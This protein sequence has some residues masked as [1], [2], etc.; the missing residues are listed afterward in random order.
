M[1]PNAKRRNDRQLTKDDASD[2]EEEVVDP[3]NFARASEDVLKQRKIVRARRGADVGGAPKAANPFAGIQL[4]AAA[5]G[6]PAANPF[7]GVS[8]TAGG[9]T[10]APTPTKPPAAAAPAAA[11][12]AQPAEQA[13][14][15]GGDQAAAAQPAAA[16]EQHAEEKAAEALKAAEAPKPAAAASGGFG[17]FGAGAGAGGGGLAFGSSGGFGSTA[18]GFGSLAGSTGA[19]FS[20][21]GA[22]TA[23]SGGSSIFSFSTTAA[24]SFGLAGG[25]AAS[26]SDA[27]PAPAPAPSAGGSLFGATPASGTPLF[28]A[29]APAAP[30]VELPQGGAVPTGEEDERTLFSGE[31][32][33]FEFGTD[34]QWRE[35]GRGEMRVNV[36]SSGQGRLVMRQKGNLRLLMNANLWGEMQVSKME[37]GKGATFA[38]VNAA[39][40]GDQGKKEGGA[41]GEAAV[42]GGE[43]AAGGDA[44]AKPAAAPHLATFA[45]R[46]KAPDVLDQFIAAVNAHKA[47]GKKGGEEA[48]A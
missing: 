17:S 3:G 39:V 25:A 4:A 19:T 46:I 47:G 33:L 34:K 40:P 44:D 37:G 1:E 27:A 41:G 18:G 15:A 36:N 35:R 11:A 24:P 32:A 30:K 6:V 20:F 8:F 2:E 26:G 13:A 31:G 43:A 28:G 12:P 21:G 45:L 5:G 16:G 9:A 14:P 22:A 29:A 42:A 48:A 23:A 38:C 7:T 10:P